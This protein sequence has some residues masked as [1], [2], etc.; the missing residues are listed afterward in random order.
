MAIPGV[1]IFQAQQYNDRN[2]W[3]QKRY[4]EPK[5]KVSAIAPGN[6]TR[7]DLRRK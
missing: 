4:P 5:P 6:R 2:N 3:Y 1:F 7:D